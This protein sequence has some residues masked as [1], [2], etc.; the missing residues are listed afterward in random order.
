MKKEIETIL[1]ES[2]WYQG[3]EISISYM[4][5]DL[6]REGF[7]IPNTLIENLLKEF[8][9]NELKFRTQND[10]YGN[11]RLNIDAAISKIDDVTIVKYELL[12]KEKLMPCGTIYFD[13]GLLFISNSE[14]IFLMNEGHFYKIGSNFFEAIENIICQN[15]IIF[16]G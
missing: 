11:I 1:N 2:A 5:E 9:N 3:R 10:M 15:D 6:Q 12:A 7:V 4:V 13:T 14:N 16:L 8:W